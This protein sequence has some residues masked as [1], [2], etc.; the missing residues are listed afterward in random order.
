M[1]IRLSVPL[2]LV[3][4]SLAACQEDRI[5]NASD[6]ALNGHWKS[7]CKIVDQVNS[8]SGFEQ[9]SLSFSEGQYSYSINLFE[10][11]NCVIAKIRTNEGQS[12]TY[13][14]GEYKLYTNRSATR[15]T[16]SGL[17]AHQILFEQQGQKDVVLNI[18]AVIDQILYLGSPL[19]MQIGVKTYP[20]ELDFDNGFLK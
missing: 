17:T 11:S 14:H 2:V 8:L 5:I 10:D 4:T 13:L 15:V 19:V 3:L 18:I 7:K 12:D 16:S 20:V 9:Q 1:K 6:R